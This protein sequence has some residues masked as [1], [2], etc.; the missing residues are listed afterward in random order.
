MNSL[1]LQIDL[2][3]IISHLLGRFMVLIEIEIAGYILVGLCSVV[4]KWHCL[5]RKLKGWAARGLCINSTQN[6]FSKTIREHHVKLIQYFI[7]GP[8]FLIWSEMDYQL[9]NL[10]SLLNSC[11]INKLIK[12][13]K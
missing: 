4:P 9:L 12:D 6:F 7:H 1:S 8:W 3:I 11:R 2:N 10:W 13:I 5:M